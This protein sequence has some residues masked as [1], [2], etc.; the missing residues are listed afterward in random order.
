MIVVHLSDGVSP[1]HV[2][3]PEDVRLRF[4]EDL[5]GDF[6][7]QV[8]ERRGRELGRQVRL[9]VQLIPV[10]ISSVVITA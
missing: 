10:M 1:I 2:D 8:L 4:G 3:V 7:V 5:E 9:R 6:E